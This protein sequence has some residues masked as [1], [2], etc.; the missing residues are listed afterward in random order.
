MVIGLVLSSCLQTNNSVS[1]DREL[2]SKREGSALF[3]AVNGVLKE[4]CQR[5]HANMMAWTQQEFLST[6]SASGNYYVKAG[7]PERSEFYLRLQG[8]GGPK[9]DMPQNGSL[10]AG[11]LKVVKDWILSLDAST[12]VLG[13]PMATP[14]QRLAA[15]RAIFNRPGGCG[16]CHAHEDTLKVFTEEQFRN[17]LS[18]GGTGDPY[19]VAGQPDDSAII[20]R[21]RGVG[22]EFMADMPPESEG[23]PPLNSADVAILKQWIQEMVVE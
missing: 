12:P 20:L 15:A 3:L 1:K 7:D 16:T 8:S 21:L 22:P 6:R 10:S 11:D 19:V 13:P 23:Y 4:S 17:T 9:A 14:A 2:Y 18:D 5:C